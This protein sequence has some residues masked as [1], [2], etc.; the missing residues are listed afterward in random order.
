MQFDT[1]YH[2][3]FSYFS[4]YTAE[5]ALLR[6]GLVVHDVEQLP[7]HGGSLRIWAGHAEV[8]RRPSPNLLHLR[9]VEH[10]AGIHRIETYAGFQ[11]RA[12]AC[13][14][15][16]LAFLSTARD[17]KQS[18]VAYGAAAKGNTLLNYCG[19][20]PDEISFVV[21]RSPHKQGHYLPGTHIPIHAPEYLLDAQPSYLLILAWNL[22]AEIMDQ[23][24][25]IKLWGGR[26]VT[27]VP[28]VFVYP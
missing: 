22:R 6:H 5:K 1:I 10:R 20:S 21:D 7:T 17:E 2:E 8:D 13:R 12:D 11:E 27:P 16:L 9:D 24:A 19:I 18:V 15:S 26:F 4:L 3:H 14:R 23:M 28:E 25:H